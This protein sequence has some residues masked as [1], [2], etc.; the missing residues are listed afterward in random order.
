[1]E[2][3]GRAGTGVDNIDL[4]AATR[5]GI[6]VMNTPGG[7]TISTAEHSMALMLSMCRNVAQAN[8]PP[9]QLLPYFP[10][11]RSDQE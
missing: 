4:D 10:S 5:K 1:M 7:N 9:G 2:V 3:I 8:H 11:K 6:I